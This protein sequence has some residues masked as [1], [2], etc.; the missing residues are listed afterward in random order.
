M[1]ECNT[2]LRQIIRRQFQR[3]FVTR[4]NAD[5]MLTHLACGICHDGVAVFQLYKETGIWQDF[6]HDAVHFN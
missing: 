4:Q 2:T 1:T 3:D 5:V 6:L